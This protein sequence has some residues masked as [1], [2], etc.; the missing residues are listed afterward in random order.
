MA[1]RRRDSSSRCVSPL[2]TQAGVEVP[3]LVE[4]KR[5]SWPNLLM[6]IGSL[7]GLWL[8][9]G[10]LTDASGSLE[11]HPQR[12]L[13]LGRGWPSCSAQLPVVTGAWALTGAV[14]GPHPLR[15]VCHFGDLEPLHLVRRWRRR[16]LRGPRAVLPAPGARRRVRHQLGR[17]RRHRELGGQG[18]PLPRVPALRG[19]RLPQAHRQQRSQG[20]SGSSSAWSSLV[21]IVAA[22]VAL[23]PKVRRLATEKARPHLVTIWTDVKEIAVEPRKVVYVLC[24][25]RREPDPHRAL[26]GRVAACGRRARQLRHPDRGADAGLHDRWRRAGS[27]RRRA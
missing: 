16:R 9:I 13:G 22:V 6:V 18:R 8:I 10:V 27:G 12:R 21:A 1:T 3:K 19:G 23:V 17:H 24:G 26:P 4:A 20:S 14:I 15:A 25:S 11:R 5:I 7:V 2:A